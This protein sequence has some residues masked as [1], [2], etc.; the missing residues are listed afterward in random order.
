MWRF[1]L[2]K[3]TK[4]SLVQKTWKSCSITENAFWTNWC[5]ITDGSQND[6]LSS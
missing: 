4:K 6:I 3:N 1:E 5:S 2:A